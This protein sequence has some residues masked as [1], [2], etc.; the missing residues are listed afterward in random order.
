M[1]QSSVYVY[2]NNL[3]KK[4]QLSQ[5]GMVEK[6][7]G[8]DEIILLEG[9]C[10][11]LS[12]PFRSYIHYTF[13]I[14]LFRMSYQIQGP[15]GTQTSIQCIIHVGSTSFQGNDVEIAL[16]QR[17]LAPQCPW[18]LLLFL[19]VSTFSWQW[20][21]NFKVKHFW[22]RTDQWAYCTFYSRTMDWRLRTYVPYPTSLM[23]QQRT[24]KTSS[25]GGVEAAIMT[26]GPPAGCPT[27]SSPL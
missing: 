10:L 2:L 20:H 8:K 1:R 7:R 6:W 13:A 12:L 26:A 23:P 27:T 21:R 19:L 4:I 15:H 11:Y 25:Q 14:A 22:E 3:I 18:K 24:Y 17:W 5:P 9:L 16:I